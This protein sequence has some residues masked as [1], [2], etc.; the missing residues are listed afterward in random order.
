[1]TDCDDDQPRSMS[2]PGVRER[3]RAMLGLPHMIALT[4]FAEKLRQ[5][6][7]GWVPDFDP[8]DGGVKAQALF[9]LYTRPRGQKLGIRV[10]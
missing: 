5:R 4:S 10:K 7:P 8:C 9:V 6:R 1:M 3:R 2:D